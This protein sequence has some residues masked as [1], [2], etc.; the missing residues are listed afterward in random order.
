MIYVKNRKPVT[1]IYYKNKIITAVYA[2]ARLVWQLIR[3]CFGSGY[4]IQDKPWIGTDA[5]KET[6]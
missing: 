3:S 4:W 1:G 6:K 2:N 5:W